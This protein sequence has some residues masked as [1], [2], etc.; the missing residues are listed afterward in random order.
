VRRAACVLVLVVAAACTPGSPSSSVTPTPRPLPSATPPGRYVAE[1]ARHEGGIVTVGDWAFPQALTPIYPQPASATYIEQALFNGLVGYDPSLQPFG[2]L[3]AEVPA[4][5]NGGVKLTGGGMDVTYRLRAGLQWSDGQPITPADVVFTWHAESGIEGYDRITG[6][7]AS[8][9]ELTV[10]FGSVYPEYPLLFSTVLPAHRLA[11]IDPSRLP[12]DAYWQKPD[13]VSGPFSIQD[14]VQGDHFTLQR[15]PHYADGRGG[16]ALLSRPAHL[17][18]LIFRAYPTKS[19]LLAAAKNGDVDLALNLSERDVP[20]LGGFTASRVQLVPALSY[21]QLALNRD[22]PLF[23]NDP[24]VAAALTLGVDRHG[25]QMDVLKGVA[26]AADSPISPQIGWVPAGPPFVQDAAAAVSRLD[27]D[28]WV[29]GSDGIRSKSNRR[30]QVTLSTTTDNPQREAEVE[31]IAAGWKRIGVEVRIQ[32]FTAAQLFA[33]YDGQGVLARGG[34]QAA[35]W[36][37]VTPPDPAAEFGTLDSARIP[38]PGKAAAYQDY[39]RC[40]DTGID[41]ALADGQSSLDRAVRARA[42]QRFIAAYQSARCEVPLYQRLDIAASSKRLHNLAPNPTASGNTWN[43]SD[44]WV[45]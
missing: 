12:G 25:V 13:V 27:A 22:D 17:D 30:L 26:P 20:T 21:E 11:S 9:S 29:T 43:V 2:D 14:A 31:E 16:Q 19:S 10:H 7:D 15:N 40:R 3:A 4:P 37:W 45:D 38:G 44:W 35:V 1:A 18:K 28:G 24:A 23:A 36:A 33:S 42:Y 8:G 41:T 39:S 6:I 5:D 32:N 34:Y